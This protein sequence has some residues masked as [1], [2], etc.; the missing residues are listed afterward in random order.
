MLQSSGCLR[1]AGDMDGQIMEWK[2]GLSEALE[3]EGGG[4]QAGRCLCTG[5]PVV[6]LCISGASGYLVALTKRGRFAYVAARMP[7]KWHACPYSWPV[8]PPT[9]EG[10]V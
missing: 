1:C 5:S 2:V 8:V 3:A 4:L 9:W 10:A 7:R 6:S